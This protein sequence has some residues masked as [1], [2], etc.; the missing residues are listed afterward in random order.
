MVAGPQ[1]AY[2]TDD[3]EL[4]LLRARLIERGQYELKSTSR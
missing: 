1:S 3:T 4:E 2:R